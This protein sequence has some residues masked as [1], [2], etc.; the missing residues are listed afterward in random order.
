[1]LQLSL[2]EEDYK[3][4]FLLHSNNCLKKLDLIACKNVLEKSIYIFSQNNE[5]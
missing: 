4:Q 2:L 5:M 3:Y 1:M